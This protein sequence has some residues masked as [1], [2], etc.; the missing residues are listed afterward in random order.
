MPRGRV[1]DWETSE[2][3][4]LPNVPVELD[5]SDPE[6]AHYIADYTGKPFRYRTRVRYRLTTD[7]VQD[8][9]M[10][11]AE[12]YRRALTG[13]LMKDIVTEEEP[14]PDYAS[15]LG[16]SREEE[17]TPEAKRYKQALQT[18]AQ[19]ITPEER[20]AV[21]ST[22]K[23]S[24]VGFWDKLWAGASAKFG[25]L[26]EWFPEWMRKDFFTGEVQRAAV[27]SPELDVL[28][29][30]ERTRQVVSKIEEAYK[31][32]Y[33]VKSVG[34]TLELWRFADQALKTVSPSVPLVSESSPYLVGQIGATVAEAI[35]IALATGY[36]LEL[37]GVGAGA[38]A[39]GAGTGLVTRLF[40]RV[41][42]Y[43]VRFFSRPLPAILGG[44]VRNATIAAVAGGILQRTEDQ[45]DPWRTTQEEIFRTAMGGITN[46]VGAGTIG[47]IAKD[48][49]LRYV[50]KNVGSDM[51]AG[52][53]G[54]VGV[55]GVSAVMGQEGFRP[56]AGDVFKTG[57]L[58]A[59]M[60]ATTGLVFSR[61][62]EL[63]RYWKAEY[64][65]GV[66]QWQQ[67]RN[68]ITDSFESLHKQLESSNQAY[69]ASPEKAKVEEFIERM[70]NIPE[71]PQRVELWTEEFNRTFKEVYNE[72]I[73]S[74]PQLSAL[75]NAIIDSKA[76][77]EY[78]IRAQKSVV[79]QAAP[80][81]GIRTF[82]GEV[83]DPAVISVLGDAS[84]LSVSAELQN[85]VTELPRLTTAEEAIASDVVRHM[86]SYIGLG[87]PALLQ[88]PGLDDFLT[89][90]IGDSLIVA[91]RGYRVSAAQPNYVHFVATE[92]LSPELSYVF[93]RYVVPEVDALWGVRASLTSLDFALANPSRLGYILKNVELIKQDRYERINQAGPFR[94][95]DDVVTPESLRAAYSNAFEQLAA[96]H[97]QQLTP[98]QAQTLASAVRTISTISKAFDGTI[99][100]DAAGE[101]RVWVHRDYSTE[102]PTILE[103]YAQLGDLLRS[104]DTKMFRGTSIGYNPLNSFLSMPPQV[105]KLTRSL[106]DTPYA[107][108]RAATTGDLLYKTIHSWVEETLYPTKPFGD[109]P[110][111]VN[112]RFQKIV[113]DLSLSG[114]IEAGGWRLGDIYR[115]YKEGTLALE[116]I[117]NTAHLL[118]DTIRKE[119]MREP[120]NLVKSDVDA[121]SY[122]ES[123]KD[124]ART[125]AEKIYYREFRDIRSAPPWME[126][127]IEKEY[128]GALA[129]LAS[130]PKVAI[131]LVTEGGAG[132]KINVAKA[133]SNYVHER[134]KQ[135]DPT[136]PVVAEVIPPT[137][138]V[139][140]VGLLSSLVYQVNPQNWNAALEKVEFHVVEETARTTATINGEQR[141]VEY[142]LYPERM[143]PTREILAAYD[144]MQGLTAEDKFFRTIATAFTG[145]E[146]A[147]T[148]EAIAVMRALEY[149]IGQRFETVVEL[150]NTYKQQAATAP[151]YYTNQFP[152]DFESAFIGNIN[153]W[154]KAIAGRQYKDYKEYTA[155]FQSVDIN[156][157]LINAF[158][159]LE[160]VVGAGLS[161][162]NIYRAL[163][164]GDYTF[165][166]PALLRN[167][168]AAPFIGS[169]LR[170]SVVTQPS[171]R[172]TSDIKPYLDQLGMLLD[173]NLLQRAGGVDIL[174]SMH[175][176]GAVKLWA[177]VDDGVTKYLLSKGLIEP[178]PDVNIVGIPTE[179]ATLREFMRLNLYHP[180]GEPMAWL[181]QYTREN[182]RMFRTDNE[183]ASAGLLSFSALKPPTDPDTYPY[184]YPIVHIP[185]NAE[186][187]YRKWHESYLKNPERV[188]GLL[189]DNPVTVDSRGYIVGNLDTYNLLARF[190]DVRRN[191]NERLRSF[192]KFIGK[193]LPTE[194][195]KIYGVV[196][197]GFKPLTNERI[198]EIKT[199][200]VPQLQP[201]RILAKY[202]REA[203]PDERI[204]TRLADI[205][206]EQY[207]K[208][209]FA[210]NQSNLQQVS[211]E[212][213]G[214]VAPEFAQ[215]ILEAEGL[216]KYT[217][218]K[219]VDWEALLSKYRNV[220]A[221]FNK[222]VA[223]I[224]E[225]S[226]SSLPD[227]TYPD[228]QILEQ[229]IK[230]Y[231]DLRNA[232]GFTIDRDSLKYS[233]SKGMLP[234]L[235]QWMQEHAEQIAPIT[236]GREPSA[237]TFDE[238]LGVVTLYADSEYKR[239]LEERAKQAELKR[240]REEEKLAAQHAKEEERLAK[241]Q[242]KEEKQR[243]REAERLAKE[244]AKEALE[245]ERQAKKQAEQRAKEEA[246]RAR[247]NARKA[248]EEERKVK[249]ALKQLQKAAQEREKLLKERLKT[250]AQAIKE[251]D[252]L[253]AQLIRRAEELK[254]MQEKYEEKLKKEQAKSKGK[255][256]PQTP[257]ASPP[258]E[259]VT[260]KVAPPSR[261]KRGG[262]EETIED[263]GQLL[264]AR[265]QQLRKKRMAMPADTDA[266]PKAEETLEAPQSQAIEN[267]NDVVR[268]IEETTQAQQQLTEQAE[269]QQQPGEGEVRGEP[270]LAEAEPPKG[271]KRKAKQ[272]PPP[273]EPQAEE[274]VAGLPPEEQQPK[275]PPEE[276]PPQQ[277]EEG[278]GEGGFEFGSAEDFLGGILSVT[279]PITVTMALYAATTGDDEDDDVSTASFLPLHA[280]LALL[281]G[282]SAMARLA[283]R[284]RLRVARF[285]LAIGELIGR[286]R[287]YKKDAPQIFANAI[288]KIGGILSR[289]P[290][291]LLS[292]ESAPNI[293]DDV[294]T[295]L[296][297]VEPPELRKGLEELVLNRVVQLTTSPEVYEDFQNVL[298]QLVAD[299][300]GK[301]HV[302]HLEIAQSVTIPPI[303]LSPERSWGNFMFG[304]TSKIGKDLGD[305]WDTAGA[306]IYG[307]SARRLLP[308]TSENFSVAEASRLVEDAILAHH[309]MIRITYKD[310][311]SQLG[312]DQL[313]PQSKLAKDRLAIRMLLGDLILGWIDPALRSVA[314]AA[315]RYGDEL[316]HIA[317][318]YYKILEAAPILLYVPQHAGAH[319]KLLNSIELGIDSLVKGEDPVN[320]LAPAHPMHDAIPTSAHSIYQAL[321]SPEGNLAQ[322]IADDVQKLVASK[323]LGS[324]YLIDRTRPIHEDLQW[325][326]SQLEAGIAAL[327][328]RGGMEADLKT[329]QKIIEQASPEEL[330]DLLVTLSTDSLLLSEARA[331]IDLYQSPAF[332]RENAEKYLEYL[333]EDI[334]GYKEVWR[335][336]G[337]TYEE[338][339]QRRLT[340]EDIAENP[341]LGVLA[342]SEQKRGEL[343]QELQKQLRPL[344]E[345]Q[346]GLVENKEAA[347]AF[348]AKLYQQ[349]RQEYD[350]LHSEITLKFRKELEPLEEKRNEIVKR[351]QELGVT[352]KEDVAAEASAEQ[353][354][355]KGTKK[356]KKGPEE[357]LKAELQQVEQQ[358]RNLEAR[359]NIELAEALE[360]VEPDEL[361]GILKQLRKLRSRKLPLVFD[362]ERLRSLKEQKAIIRG[363][364]DLLAQPLS[365][366]AGKLQNYIDTIRNLKLLDTVEKETPPIIEDTTLRSETQDALTAEETL[367]WREHIERFARA[368][369][370]DE[371]AGYGKFLSKLEALYAESGRDLQG[372]IAEFAEKYNSLM[373]PD[374]PI[375]QDPAQYIKTI[376]EYLAAR[377]ALLDRLTGIVRK[378]RA[379]PGDW[380]KQLTGAL[381]LL[382]KAAGIAG[383]AK[384]LLDALFANP[385][386]S[387]AQKYEPLI[388]EYRKSQ[389]VDFI[390][391]EGERRPHYTKEAQEA[392]KLRKELENIKEQLKTYAEKA[393]AITSMPHEIR[394][395]YP[396]QGVI[397][398]VETYAR[399]IG[400]TDITPEDIEDGIQEAL[401]ELLR[402]PQRDPA[403]ARELLQEMTKVENGV[404][405]YN[406]ERLRGYLIQW[407]KYKTQEVFRGKVGDESIV[408]TSGEEAD[409]GGIG[410]VSEERELA[411]T[412]RSPDEIIEERGAL[413]KIEALAE[414][415][416]MTE[417]ELE[418]ALRHYQYGRKLI[419]ELDKYLEEYPEIVE[420][421]TA[422]MEEYT[423]YVE[424][425][426]REN[427][428]YSEFVNYLLQQLPDEALDSERSEALSRVRLATY[429]H[430]TKLSPR[431]SEFYN[432]VVATM[433]RPAPSTPERPIA[434]MV[435]EW[436]TYAANLREYRAIMD[437]YEGTEGRRAAR[438]WLDEF[439]PQMYSTVARRLEDTWGT[440]IIDSRLSHH[441]RRMLSKKHKELGD[442]HV[443]NVPTL[444][445][446]YTVKDMVYQL[447]DQ[448][449][450]ADGSANLEQGFLNLQNRYYSAATRIYR[451]VN[452]VVQAYADE[453]FPLFVGLET[454]DA[455]PEVSKKYLRSLR[456]Q[457]RLISATKFSDSEGR[458]YYEVRYIRTPEEIDQLL[459]QANSDTEE[460]R[461]LRIELLTLLGA[462]KDATLPNNSE[463]LRN[464]IFRYMARMNRAV[465]HAGVEGS[466][467]DIGMVTAIHNLM[468]DYTEHL[469][470]SILLYITRLIELRKVDNKI[471]D[472]RPEEYYN[473]LQK[474]F[475]PENQ[476]AGSESFP[477][478]WQ[479]RLGLNQELRLRRTEG[480][481]FFSVIAPTDWSLVNAMT[482]EF[483]N[484]RE[485]FFRIE[486]ELSADLLSGIQT[487]ERVVRGDMSVTRDEL[488]AFAAQFSTIGDRGESVL[489]AQITRG[490]VEGK[491]LRGPQYLALSGLSWHLERLRRSMVPAGKAIGDL[492]DT[493]NQAAMQWQSLSLENMTS[494]IT[495]FLRTPEEINAVTSAINDY[496]EVLP[497][498]FP[499]V[500]IKNTGKGKVIVIPGAE[501]P[502][503]VGQLP[504]T[505]A[506]IL[507][508]TWEVVGVSS[509]LEQVRATSDGPQKI[510]DFFNKLKDI[511]TN[512]YAV[513]RYGDPSAEGFEPTVAI[514]RAIVDY[515]FPDYLQPAAASAARKITQEFYALLK[516]SG[517]NR[518]PSSIAG[519]LAGEWYSR[520]LSLPIFGRPNTQPVTPISST[521][522]SPEAGM[523]MY[524]LANGIAEAASNTERMLAQQGL[525]LNLSQSLPIYKDLLSG[526]GLR[527]LYEEYVLPN[528]ENAV[529]ILRYMESIYKYLEGVAS[530]V[531][532]GEQ[533][534]LY[535]A[536]GELSNK[537]SAPIED[538]IIRNFAYKEDA[539]FDDVPRLV[540]SYLRGETP[541]APQPTPHELPVEKLREFLSGPAVKR[542]IPTSELIATELLRR[543]LSLRGID[544]PQA[545]EEEYPLYPAVYQLAKQQKR[546]LPSIYDKAQTDKGIL[547]IV[548]NAINALA[549]NGEQA[550]SETIRQAITQIAD[551]IDIKFL[552]NLSQKD[553]TFLPE[554]PRPGSFRVVNSNNLPLYALGA[555]L[556]YEYGWG[557]NEDD[558][559]K[560]YVHAAILALAGKAAHGK[561]KGAVEKGKLP[562]V[563]LGST[564]SSNIVRGV[565]T[566]M[567]TNLFSE[568]IE[569]VT[570]M[571]KEEINAIL[572]PL[573]GAMA[574]HNY[575]RVK[576][577]TRGDISK[578]VSRNIG[579]DFDRLAGNI[580]VRPAIL[581]GILK[582]GIK[583]SPS[584]QHLALSI[585]GSEASST[586]LRQVEKFLM[587]P[588]NSLN[589][590]DTLA[591]LITNISE[592]TVEAAPL[593]Q[594]G[595]AGSN[596]MQAAIAQ[597]FAKAHIIE[598]QAEQ[599]IFGLNVLSSTEKPIVPHENVIRSRME[600]V[601]G[602]LANSPQWYSEGVGTLLSQIHQPIYED[603]PLIAA[604]RAAI[605]VYGPEQAYSNFKAWLNTE[606]K[607]RDKELATIARFAIELDKLTTEYLN[608]NLPVE[609]LPAHVHELER[610]FFE[611]NKEVFPNIQL[612]Y[613]AYRAVNDLASAVQLR[614]AA[615]YMLRPDSFA[616]ITQLPEVISQM[617]GK[618]AE[619][620]EAI[621]KIEEQLQYVDE[622]EMVSLM[623]LH[624][625]LSL[626]GNSI[627]QRIENAQKTVQLTQL[628]VLRRYISR[629]HHQRG[630]YRVRWKERIGEKVFD[631]MRVFE[632]YKEAKAFE[633]ELLQT[634]RGAIEPTSIRAEQSE[635]EKYA[636]PGIPVDHL[637]LLLPSV[638]G[639]TMLG[640]KEPM[641][642]KSI[643][644]EEAI[645][646]VLGAISKVAHDYIQERNPE[647]QSHLARYLQSKIEELQNELR[648]AGRLTEETEGKIA[649]G[650]QAAKHGDIDGILRFVTDPS[651]ATLTTEYT[652]LMRRATDPLKARTDVRG[653]DETLESDED[654]R[655]FILT[656]ISTML[657][658]AGSAQSKLYKI[659]TLEQA[660]QMLGLMNLVGAPIANKIKEATIRLKVPALNPLTMGMAERFSVLSRWVISIGAL[661]LNIISSVRNFFEA[662]LQHAINAAYDALIKRTPF[663]VRDFFLTPLFDSEGRVRDPILREA[664]ETAAAIGLYSQGKFSDIA[665]YLRLYDKRERLS[666]LGFGLQSVS[667][668]EANR[669]TFL[670]EYRRALA[671]YAGR[672]DAREAAFIDGLRAIYKT[673]GYLQPEGQSQF[674]YKLNQVP[675][676]NVLLT[677]MTTTLRLLYQTVA[678]TVAFYKEGKLLGDNRIAS[679]LLKMA[680]YGG[681]YFLIA[682]LVRG[683]QNV[684]ILGDI[685]NAIQGAASLFMEEDDSG[686]GLVKESPADYLK[687]KAHEA[688]RSIGLSGKQVEFIADL[689]SKG[690]L[691]TLTDYNMATSSNLTQ[692]GETILAT[693]G[694]ALGDLYSKAKSGQLTAGDVA[695]TITTL[696]SPMLS[697]A[698]RAV[699]Q[700]ADGTYYVGN[701]PTGKP[702]A[703][704]DIVP[705]IAMGLPY[706]ITKDNELLRNGKP[707][708]SGIRERRDFHDRLLSISGITVQK[709]KGW[710]NIPD[711]WELQL[712]RNEEFARDLWLR[713]ID[714]YY[715]VWNG[716][717]GAIKRKLS[718]Q[719]YEFYENYYKKLQLEGVTPDKK[720]QQAKRSI[721]KMVE[722]MLLAKAFLT[723]MLYDKEFWSKHGT[724]PP[725]FPIKYKIAG[726]VETSNPLVIDRHLETLVGAK[727]MQLLRRT[728]MGT[729]EEFGDA[730]IRAMARQLGDLLD[731]VAMP[732]EAPEPIVEED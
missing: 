664:D 409:E 711:A 4:Y 160:S 303:S 44:N 88:T 394:A 686:S 368:M 26:W 705:F 548:D 641:A 634:R 440:E 431:L 286:V 452:A 716:R 301:K 291:R 270:P 38:A 586:W 526:N 445:Q 661:S 691:T 401:I 505:M 184:D 204:E 107:K 728:A 346:R 502:V 180:N 600:T 67:A 181:P 304:Y 629:W 614:T 314:P 146:F 300:Y 399:I 252:K 590:S 28:R 40:P 156:K 490:Q 391:P 563:V 6:D 58:S 339:Q 615:M 360:R 652:T 340:R 244:R 373:D 331:L 330:G 282:G 101:V 358:I 212:L 466:A 348:Y 450:V 34:S 66:E 503:P 338:T 332:R 256:Q 720:L 557:D 243:L 178:K 542:G 245:R 412:F 480:A 60:A 98:E 491:S 574:F 150:V 729:K 670:R 295:V 494:Y 7:P 365:S 89:K 651:L 589:K 724:P 153:H 298:R 275:A 130:D 562:Y 532:R 425:Q 493:I 222:T 636:A 46:I 230:E 598:K 15:L 380:E 71:K 683:M 92:A 408:T 154:I 553:A 632:T 623:G 476:E 312:F 521:A 682:G 622:E 649:L 319:L 369:F 406:Y 272:E 506:H 469:T 416:G 597:H 182:V 155:Y 48:G 144:A 678:D 115:V 567:L 284:Q 324:L 138:F 47:S 211:R 415:L 91:R 137:S 647:V 599:M 438:R 552:R 349:R 564:Y 297:G 535:L 418:L 39:A 568:Q 572:I 259:E 133:I 605:D 22:L 117:L 684:Q 33:G 78:Y 135:V 492:F 382:Y 538:A 607:V 395:V 515:S 423:K 10:R 580:Y 74:S 569:Q 674:E 316:P 457:N 591:R 31:Q 308:I 428:P 262:Q 141:V 81:V 426:E 293:V 209:F 175:G 83:L 25:A 265:R 41:A 128:Q 540:N 55:E 485:A 596:I 455:S 96:L 335:R 383:N 205:V 268:A 30:S 584:A 701:D 347:E 163:S 273:Q 35:G 129:H 489:L 384:N 112:E 247:D 388:E 19:S 224:N 193:K 43:A 13:Q 687:R 708:F 463:E 721:N 520:V 495:R 587:L 171:I 343:V 113:Q 322:A 231:V 434:K 1:T 288:M 692:M 317:D 713:L 183:A 246:R 56:E 592:G 659:H 656:G 52:F 82:K 29:Q 220:I 42:P 254:K 196:I 639:T 556:A 620:S 560:Q 704:Y 397:K 328:N 232:V 460:G 638:F 555:A 588:E 496:V 514:A 432:E 357:K 27:G 435:H 20:K 710:E 213:F 378:S 142:K 318:F 111:T 377:A 499:N 202:L 354:P 625:M 76:T 571:S 626:L 99:Y 617:A 602:G 172:I 70:R 362:P 192:A 306:S 64:K 695:K 72:T 179:E 134:A 402:L 337:L 260:G 621:S 269:A 214:D 576:T 250:E 353:A 518:H 50:V 292:S 570:G 257:R 85:A 114:S 703:L 190:P 352:T 471:L 497:R 537:S 249:E 579:L 697:R 385:E 544:L 709:P 122:L 627:D 646:S 315:L 554:L 105:A 517:I 566:L 630:N 508:K 650:L 417:A 23:S 281:A 730:E 381:A 398:T 585:L 203:A 545:F 68:L 271:R 102:S 16:L 483:S 206:Y 54:G 84:K 311:L 372:D 422:G 715:K 186:E 11:E 500:Q 475:I 185:R 550:Q 513:K 361:R 366:I 700:A 479:W 326:A 643:Y 145:Q 14:L 519:D 323:Q 294:R 690:W 396:Y 239:I 410:E 484:I 32:A 75:Y 533:P 136:Q 59:A 264:Q 258:S 103:T 419:T 170:L 667:E 194:A 329:M 177:R 370:E 527:R 578:R 673:Q 430:A 164:S 236:G 665:E 325:A 719:L 657:Y 447:L 198:M 429:L 668:Y 608:E 473:L 635:E 350:K 278:T 210:P 498:Y 583:P 389:V 234:R 459:A 108:E 356:K 433:G 12:G 61:P 613:Y 261:R 698:F 731:G 151:D 69:A 561:V 374:S 169:M 80:E 609:Q 363:T 582:G 685:A 442:G 97:G 727:F 510:T 546:W 215:R 446:T 73:G 376:G 481:P 305:I 233:T 375:T 187:H 188:I 307:F 478:Y 420:R 216:I 677:L 624:Q 2:T 482:R 296:E 655:N 696:I 127:V 228:R 593:A 79:Q 449:R 321:W 400:N 336:A 706:S 722:E 333:S 8:S 165:L 166:T 717:P 120:G 606:K 694:R 504:F 3:W 658:R 461:N 126:R 53:V 511:I 143:K 238:Y 17:I 549:E 577:L 189:L 523:F 229:R 669:V 726:I 37:L 601:L 672:K 45:Y 699:Q 345:E 675:G 718:D 200:D 364:I 451:T 581:D 644:Q 267:Y 253:I 221:T 21:E 454:I 509:L 444:G 241:L 662:R 109:A 63:Y 90:V 276:Q 57:M 359:Y 287:D 573:F 313:A 414:R 152:R 290:E 65:A 240:I 237:L 299:K 320:L 100:R 424:K 195:D 119:Y 633:D 342:Q 666:K 640:G 725:I 110:S 681:T 341:R 547:R 530:A 702:F 676:I 558:Q 5:P 95:F 671:K 723:T 654:Y 379:A 125:L 528:P 334:E 604:Y 94:G 218:T 191:Y 631:K 522:V 36:G 118:R 421:T 116:K 575:H 642:Y 441:I 174:K 387:L 51:L 302:K 327:A 266:A 619:I 559:T 132:N 207:V 235:L 403:L 516:S 603:L 86:K 217:P 565:T 219:E 24:E 712:L 707:V 645:Q 507:P 531:N 594:G 390:T 351:L 405:V 551:A 310:L 541:D 18:L 653:Y 413:S 173:D 529:G 679:G 648:K 618:R 616:P 289:S 161:Y 140:P 486:N 472:T 93:N 139:Q 386:L 371:N 458:E 62:G 248:R 147:D 539:S 280:I 427:V 501:K 201:S 199:N 488:N 437:S 453:I 448:R 407:A 443:W 157:D 226:A 274:P 487:L 456:G 208:F 732:P 680:A 524:Q 367:Q 167:P 283:R 355:A 689:F 263:V 148:A 439:I 512:K 612:T 223:I 197:H 251:R 595:L 227:G 693:K 468:R 344:T 610:R 77:T 474:Y 123:F 536:P 158:K 714:N 637:E 225:Y 534:E 525:S 162:E 104:Y 121:V 465:Q 663:A 131:R 660:M 9:I 49:V 436:Q 688:G 470:K 176:A 462:K 168:K 392:E 279:D 124:R 543:T 628:S 393:A 255:G 285:P 242:A 411:G 467:E 464:G 611:A 277:P 87:E 309:P 106:K 404:T 477:V 159:K 149:G